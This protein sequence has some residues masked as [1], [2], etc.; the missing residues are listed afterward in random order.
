[1]SFVYFLVK[2]GYSDIH[3]NKHSTTRIG[4]AH[5]TFFSSS[6]Y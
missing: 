3:I 6:K 4:Y 5:H 2:F 1:M